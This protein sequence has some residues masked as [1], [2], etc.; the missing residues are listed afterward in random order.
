MPEEQLD[1]AAIAAQN[2]AAV[3]AIKTGDNEQTPEATPEL[4]EVEQQAYDQ[5]WRPKEEFSGDGDWIDAKEFIA[6]GELY[7]GLSKQNKKIKRM[8]EMLRRL[9]ESRRKEEAEELAAKK[10]AIKRK[11]VQALEDGDAEAVVDLE[12]E[13]RKLDQQEQEVPVVE[14]PT[15]AAWKEDNEWYEEN[16]R[17]QRYANTFGAEYQAQHPNITEQE[18]YEAVAEE[19]KETFPHVFE[20]K[21]K[22]KLPNRGNPT[23]A[24]GSGRGKGG[25]SKFSQLS[26]EE[27]RACK[28]F[29]DMGVFKDADEYIAMLETA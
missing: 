20:E 13:A 22:G 15:F 16:P 28:E 27:Q 12:E 9:A 14:T 6:R 7:S 2:A 25:A 1:D 10:Q 3:A 29:V 19:V 18:L 23:G 5:G 17:L 4:N 21:P 8:E 11:R 24:Q 26:P